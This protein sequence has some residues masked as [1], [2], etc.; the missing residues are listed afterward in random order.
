MTC[1]LMMKSLTSSLRRLAH[2]LFAVGMVVLTTLVLILLRDVLS[3]SIVALLYLVPV[4][5][6]AGLWGRLAGIAAS[7]LSFLIFNYFFISP[8]YTLQVGHPQ[9]FL[10]MIV[11]L[12]VALL[13]S[14][15]MARVQSNLI[16]A[17]SRERE[18]IQ[19]YKLSLDLTGESDETTIAKILAQRLSEVF[20]ASVVEIE[21]NQ[22]GEKI[23]VTIPECDPC[24]P[25]EPV[26]RIPLASPHGLLGE[27]RIWKNLD[28][29]QPEEERVLETFARQGVLA[30]DRAILT[31]GETRA[32]VLEESDRLKTAILSSVS[33]ELRTPLAS[34]QAAA[35]SLFNPAVGLEPAARSELQSLLVEETDRMAQLVGNLLN[36]S[37]IEA[38]ALKLQ[39]QWNS[40]A[41]IVDTSVERLR[42]SIARHVIEVD[43]SEDLPFVAVD[44]VLMEQVVVNLINNS[45]KFAPTNTRICISAQADD[46]VLQVTVSN[47]G[48]PIPEEYLDHIFEK[49]YPIP[50]KESVQG[51]GLGLSICKGIVEAHGGKIWAANLPGGVAFNFTL[52]LAWDGVR[53]VLPVKEEGDEA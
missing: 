41:E 27:I 46:Q 47:Q 16:K 43:V 10:A 53:P 24:G 36:M 32:R 3:T 8:F 38:G 9:D 49:F 48:P 15:L 22:G 39:R 25:G 31:A 35:T 52:P 7:V 34:I 11:L 28:A 45:V 6:S 18:A 44:S 37:R 13:I 33:H 12:G 5:V 42:R 2:L 1:H 4:V 20:R 50:G 30:L 29:L 51:T 23:C 21:V 14:S 19:L 26:K 17:Q 40:F